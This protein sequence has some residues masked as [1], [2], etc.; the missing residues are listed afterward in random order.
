MKTYYKLASDVLRRR[1]E[2]L[3]KKEKR[4][5]I[6][7][8]V[9]PAT[10]S[11]CLVL[12]IAFSVLLT[13]G[14]TIAP[15]TDAS[16]EEDSS[17]I[18][19]QT[20]GSGRTLFTETRTYGDKTVLGGEFGYL[21][22]WEYLTNGERYTSLTYNGTEYRTRSTEISPSLLGETL[23]NAW[24]SGYD[25]IL[26]VKHSS[27]CTVYE[28][29]GI[30][31]NLLVAVQI[32]N[33]DVCYV[34]L[35]ESI[36]TP[37]SLGDMM[38]AFSLTEALTLSYFYNYESKTD[39][40]LTRYVLGNSADNT[41]IWQILSECRTAPYTDDY[42]AVARDER[43]SFAISS[44]ALGIRNKAFT[45][46]TDGYVKTNLADYGFAY[47]IGE[48]AAQ[49]IIDYVRA[50]A[51]EVKND[52]SDGYYLAGTVTEIGNGY[53]RVDDSILMQNPDDGLV[54][55]VFL[56]GIALTRYIEKG[57]IG[58]GDTVQ[59]WYDG[60]IYDSDGLLTIETV[61][62]IDEAIVTGDGEVLIPE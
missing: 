24:V 15:P 43:V 31:P 7:Y 20:D 53:I 28:I 61:Y 34:F 30:K 36:D 60:K 39:S 50:R 12:V 41:L 44:E 13:G 29:A 1:D 16:S 54:F 33:D 14:N 27:V 5:K 49:R 59:I 26:S 11:C 51:T 62:T 6:L 45:V 40:D 46:G 18:Q 21:W 47:Y 17:S 10:A 25:N 2:Y 3:I 38:D 32:A 23:G 35:R 55:T 56:K 22:E 57:I 37:K 42:T 8:K 19:V 58:V 9:I 4:R 48:D 52:D